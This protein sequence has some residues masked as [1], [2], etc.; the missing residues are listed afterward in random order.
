MKARQH[1]LLVQADGNGSRVC[2]T[3]LKRIAEL[4][5]AILSIEALIEDR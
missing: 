1:D 4:E 5:N 2:R 3:L